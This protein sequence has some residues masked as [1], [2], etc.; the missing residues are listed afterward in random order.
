M[1][2]NYAI[3]PLPLAQ[4]SILPNAIFDTLNIFDYMYDLYPLGMEDTLKAFCKKYERH[5]NKE[6][7]YI[8][9][10]TAIGRSA[11]KGS[12]HDL[13]IETLDNLGWDIVEHPIGQA[14]EHDNKFE[15]MKRWFAKSGLH[16]FRIHEVRCQQLITSME[17][18]PAKFDNGITKKDKT[19]EKKLE[20]IAAEDATHGSDASDQILWWAY[21]MDGISSMSDGM[22]AM[23]S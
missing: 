6:F 20:T 4:V 23:K 22:D 14:P 18:A 3:S 11:R 13:F 17:Q 5:Q 12:Y 16:A 2:Y 8:F 1:D 7:H 15:K 10:H 21:E 19:S 9:D